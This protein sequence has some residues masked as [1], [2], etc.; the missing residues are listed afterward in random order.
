MGV[1]ILIKMIRNISRF[2]LFATHLFVDNLLEFMSLRIV[3]A[4]QFWYYG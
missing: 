1:E 3:E 4:F 2:I